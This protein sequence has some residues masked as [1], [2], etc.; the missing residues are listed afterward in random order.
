MQDHHKINYL[1]IP[2]LDMQ[3]T[4]NFFSAVFEW[5]FTDYGPEYCS[6]DNAAIDGGFYLAD[7]VA[8]V[9]SGSVLIVLYSD[10]L[11]SSAAKVTEHGGS[12]VRETFSFPGGSRFHFKDPNGNEF[13]VWKKD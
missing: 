7:K 1:E 2:A 8:S 13:A 4:K 6:F 11:S 10:D 12:I 9:A 5:G 3:A